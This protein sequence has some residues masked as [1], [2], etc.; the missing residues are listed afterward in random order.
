[1]TKTILQARRPL[2]FWLTVRIKTIRV[3]WFWP[4]RIRESRCP[5]SYW[6]IRCW[7][8]SSTRPRL[9]LHSILR[10]STAI[11]KA[12]SKYW[13]RSTTKSSTRRIKMATRQCILWCVTSQT[14]LCNASKL[15]WNYWRKEAIC[16]WGTVCLILRWFR[17]FTSSRRM[18]SAS[19]SPTTSSTGTRARNSSISMRRDPRSISVLC[20]LLSSRTTSSWYRFCSSTATRCKL[21]T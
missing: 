7:T 17:R 2:I 21:W 20:I 4:W 1:M 16:I 15:Q 13:T 9:F 18:Q 11:S 6:S 3:R 5:N 8:R 12:A 14:I 19:P 10:S